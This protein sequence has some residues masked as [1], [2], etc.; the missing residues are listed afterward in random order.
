MTVSNPD[1]GSKL[2]DS[3]VLVEVSLARAPGISQT[4]T[5]APGFFTTDVPQTDLDCLSLQ[6]RR[7]PGCRRCCAGLELRGRQP[8]PRRVQVGNGLPSGGYARRVWASKRQGESE[9]A[10]GKA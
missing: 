5:A 6:R 2:A 3:L 8:Q 10:I 1:F 7:L 9:T 4:L